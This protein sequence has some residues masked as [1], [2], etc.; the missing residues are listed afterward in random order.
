MSEKKKRT[1]FTGAFYAANVMEIFERLGWYGYFAVAALYLTGKPEDGCLGFTDEQQGM[2][3][4]VVTFILYLLPVIT[5]GLADRYG[6]KKMFALAYL[7]LIPAYFLLGQ[8][9]SFGGFFAVFLVVALGAAIF[10]PL[11][12]GTVARETDETNSRFGFGVFYWMVN[13]GG[14]IGP[15]V[16]AI[17]RGWGWIWVFTLSSG[18]IAFNMIWLFIFYKEKR[19]ESDS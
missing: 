11:V 1:K 9:T 8:V 6:F 19:K 17:V 3:Q 16:A 15:L 4:G 13:V 7:I 10:K 12:V 5:G 2:M 18:Y 14:F